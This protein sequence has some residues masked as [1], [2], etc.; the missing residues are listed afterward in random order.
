M[1][2][3][4]CCSKLR[5]IVCTVV[6]SKACDVDGHQTNVPQSSKRCIR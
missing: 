3:I 5:A 2:N 6:R 4:S 1:Y